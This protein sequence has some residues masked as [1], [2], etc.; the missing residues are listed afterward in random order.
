MW[1]IN[2]KINIY[3]KTIMAIYKLRSRTCLQQWNYSLELKE[4]E[5]GKENNRATVISY[6]IR[7]EGKGYKEV[8]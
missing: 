2:P 8:Y 5:K 7:C 6:T 1:K 3:T 4:R